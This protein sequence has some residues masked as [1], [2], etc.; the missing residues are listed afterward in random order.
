MSETVP[1]IA[2]TAPPTLDHVVGQ[3]QAVEQLRVALAAYWNERAAGRAAS[4]GG[5]LMSGPAGVG[6]TCMAKILASEL[7]ANLKEVLGQSLDMGEDFHA[8]LMES[9]DDTVLFI[10]E[11]HLIREFAQTTLFR[12]I[13][14]RI[15]LVPKGPMCNKHTRIPLSRFT[16]VLAT[17]DPQG[18]LAP[19]RE[20]MS[21]VLH[22]DFY[23]VEELA[24]LCR[25]RAH[26][27]KWQAE[28]EVF[29]LIAQRA[30]GVPRLALRLLQSCWRTA[31]AENADAVTVAHFHRT[32][33][34]EGLDPELGLDK[35]EQAYLRMLAESRGRARITLLASKLGQ[36]VQAVARVTEAFL[37][38]ANLV[39]RTE[40]GRELTDK[41]WDYVRR[42]LNQ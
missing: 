30:K 3:K 39:T 31:R 17:T 15:L 7:G 2:S 13:E 23:S 27:L 19:L 8:V 26:A 25:Q 22:F 4:F 18:I 14:E 35:S 28:P 10:D 11:A 33:Q 1:D 12:A 6:K 41:G 16:T 34:L 42:N 29:T 40:G 32:I 9:N 20:R 5:V 38:R 24:L 21:L 36:P 37:L